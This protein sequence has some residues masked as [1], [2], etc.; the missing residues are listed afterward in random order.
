MN[1]ATNND[2]CLTVIKVEF[3]P[4]PMSIDILAVSDSALSY[5]VSEHPPVQLDEKYPLRGAIESYIDPTE[6]V[7]EDDWEVLE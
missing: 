5:S 4:V 7:G 2:G 3:V 1:S 6:P